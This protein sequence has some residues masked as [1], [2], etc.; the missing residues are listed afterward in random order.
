M[1]PPRSNPRRSDP[2]KNFQFRVKLDG[3]YVAGL[4]G[5]R[6]LTHQP[7]QVAHRDR[8]DAMTITNVAGGR[9]YE[10]IV[11]ERVVTFDAEFERWASSMMTN[12]PGAADATLRDARKDLVIE[13]YDESG[14][15]ALAYRLQ[16]AWVSSCEALPARDAGANAAAILTMTIE[17][18]GWE[19][20]PAENVSDR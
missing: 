8:G 2:Y 6:A 13:A 18:E 1:K 14:A 4:S 17:H 11:L 5:V 15:L 7:E 19:R 10:P 20:T 9:K 16:G 12:S 3:R